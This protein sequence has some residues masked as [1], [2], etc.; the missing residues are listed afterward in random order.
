MSA[1]VLQK[2]SQLVATRSMSWKQL[3]RNNNRNV[4]LVVNAPVNNHREIDSQL[5]NHD[6]FYEE[7][8]MYHCSCT[9]YYLSSTPQDN[10]KGYQIV[11]WDRQLLISPLMLIL[12]HLTFSFHGAYIKSLHLMVSYAHYLI[13]IFINLNSNI[14]IAEQIIKII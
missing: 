4:Y 11:H 10:F 5:Q 6:S 2:S 7:L 9:Q 14:K 8:V 1:V 13:C 12:D 3:Y